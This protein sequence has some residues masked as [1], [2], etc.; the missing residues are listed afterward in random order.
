MIAYV[1][2]RVAALTLDTAVVEVGGVG[3]AVRCTP[4]T[5]AGLRVGE[6]GRLSTTLIVR[7]DDL[8]LYGF[9]DDDERGTFETVQTVSGIGPRI[10]Q[11]LLAVLTPDALRRAVADE[12]LTALMRV[13]GIGK[14]GA[15]RLVLE[16]KDKLGAP[17]G[18]ELPQ[19][20][21]GGGEPWRDQVAEALTGLGYSAK[22]AESALE[23]VA[24]LAEDGA[25][26]G[27]LLRAALRGL[28]R[29]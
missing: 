18:P 13:P 6:T 28:S 2:G 19:Q 20:A 26:V 7:E 11:A 14:K 3:L 10:A 9:A 12:D 23:S 25:D 21:S 4:G 22:D 16:L 29:A 8:T 15:Q 24:P 5:L 1:A 17:S 27:A